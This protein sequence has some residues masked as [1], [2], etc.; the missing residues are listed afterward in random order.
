VSDQ[1]KIGPVQAAIRDYVGCQPGSSKAA[2]LRGVGLPTRGFG[3]LRPIERAE[4]AGLIIVESG[5]PCR[6]FASAAD[7][8]L[9]YVKRELL[10][11]PTPERAAE[12]AA[13]A[14]E[15]RA[16]QAQSYAEAQERS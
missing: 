12:L 4:A 11:G 2:V 9:F 5:W 1:P 8:R 14:A 13:E 6:L 7:R 3:Y 10:A 15:I 16:G